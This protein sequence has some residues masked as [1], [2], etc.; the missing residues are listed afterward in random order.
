MKD[1]DTGRLSIYWALPTFGKVH[2]SI[3]PFVSAYKSKKFPHPL[4]TKTSYTIADKLKKFVC[5]R[6]ELES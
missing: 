6:L 3:T 1:D 4:E 2:Y 5:D